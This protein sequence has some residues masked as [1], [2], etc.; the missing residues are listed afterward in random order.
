M[1]GECQGCSVIDD[2]LSPHGTFQM[3]LDSTMTM[4]KLLDLWIG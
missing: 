1:G 4:A 3:V 2:G